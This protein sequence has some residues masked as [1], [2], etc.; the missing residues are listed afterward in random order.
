MWS[1]G[2]LAQGYHEQAATV[3]AYVYHHHLES[4]LEEVIQNRRWESARQ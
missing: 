3:I 1:N 2:L 4:L